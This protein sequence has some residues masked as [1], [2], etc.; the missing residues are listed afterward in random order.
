MVLAQWLTK[1]QLRVKLPLQVLFAEVAEQADALR[2]GRSGL[3]AHVGSTPTFGT[4]E[5]RG[6]GFLRRKPFLFVFMLIEGSNPL[7]GLDPCLNTNPGKYL[8]GRDIIKLVK[9]KHREVLWI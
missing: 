3:Y 1:F 6:N 7:K 8:A 9:E 4:E 2:S 5:K